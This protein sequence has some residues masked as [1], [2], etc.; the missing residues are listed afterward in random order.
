[1]NDCPIVYASATFQDLTGYSQREVVGRNCRFLQA[2]DGLVRASQPRHYVDEEAVFKLKRGVEAGEEVQQSLI[3]YRKGGSPFLNLLTLIPVP[4]GGDSIRFW[5]G[6]QIDLVAHPEAITQGRDQ[7][8][9]VGYRITGMT[10]E[11]ILPVSAPGRLAVSDPSQ[12]EEM[13]GAQQGTNEVVD[14]RK[15]KEAVARAKSR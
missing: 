10:P 2:P 8:I 15:M 1:M 9:Q 7:R 4:W 3:N 11:D 5:V 14:M 13:L 6:F 12:C